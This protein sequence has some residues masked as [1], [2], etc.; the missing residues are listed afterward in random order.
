MIPLRI[1]RLTLRAH[2]GLVVVVAALYALGGDLWVRYLLLL[3]AAL[4]LHELAHAG[5]SLAFRAERA[6]VSIWP[7]GGVAHVQRFSDHREA[8]VALAGPVSNLVVAGAALIAGG[9]F[10]LELGN[11]PPLDFVLTCNL[12]MGLIN[13]L[14]FPGLDGGRIVGILLGPRSG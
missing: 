3:L 4:L 1:G 13:L 9:G 14:P 5:V 12:L 2:V 11:C 6:V 10:S 8:L 7:W